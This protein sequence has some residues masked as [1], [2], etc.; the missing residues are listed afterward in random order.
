MAYSY[1]VSQVVGQKKDQRT[2][3]SKEYPDCR[4]DVV[5]Y[6]AGPS[7]VLRTCPVSPTLLGKTV[8]TVQDNLH[9]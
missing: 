4:F 5:G 8:T 1:L 7:S 6:F 2:K 9:C 3:L